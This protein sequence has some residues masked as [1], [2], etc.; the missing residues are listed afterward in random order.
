MR[1]TCNLRW[2]GHS[3]KQRSKHRT[4]KPKLH[5]RTSYGR[6]TIARP[7]GEW[8]TFVMTP[9]RKRKAENR[10]SERRFEFSSAYLLA[11]VSVTC[12]FRPRFTALIFQSI[13]A[14]QGFTRPS[15]PR[16]SR[17]LFLNHPTNLLLIIERKACQRFNHQRTKVPI[18]HSGK[19]VMVTQ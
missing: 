9:I 3:E 2:R 8:R 19:Q 16:L 17:L 13:S 5:G 1:D 14:S 10:N 7:P 12:L 11:S 6:R 18:K 15:E 4:C